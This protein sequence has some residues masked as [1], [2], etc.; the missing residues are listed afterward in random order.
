MT[1]PISSQK[2][3]FRGENEDKL[4]NQLFVYR[5]MKVLGESLSQLHPI[6]PDATL[7]AHLNNLLSSLDLKVDFA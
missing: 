3:T 4:Q 5:G 2:S 7:L 6:T 1:Q